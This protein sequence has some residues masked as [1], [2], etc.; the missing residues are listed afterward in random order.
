M[1]TKDMILD[2]AYACFLEQGLEG[3]SLNDIIKHTGLTKGAFYHHFKSK[4]DLIEAMIGKYLY[5]RLDDHIQMFEGHGYDARSKL[6]LMV[7][8]ITSVRGPVSVN[9]E[10]M[11][12]FQR[13]MFNGLIKNDG[14]QDNNKKNFHKIHETL[15]TILEQGVTRGDFRPDIDVDKVA[16]LIHRSMMGTLHQYMVRVID[17]LESR[18][19]ET[20]NTII[21]MIKIP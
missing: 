12:K 16:C 21:E 8:S 6:K 17:D 15:V 18:L 9:S 5:K 4:Q 20:L 2:T 11:L 10:E 14:L 19:E 1:A 13:L 3:V 7:A